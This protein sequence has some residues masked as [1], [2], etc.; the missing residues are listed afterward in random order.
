M[1]RATR[2]PNFSLRTGCPILKLRADENRIF[3]ATQLGELGFDAIILGTGFVVDWDQR[4]EL[5]RL[6]QHAA[7]W[8]DRYVPAGGEGHEFAVHPW[9]DPWFAF[10]ERTPG[11]APWIGRVHCFNYAATMSQ[12]KLTGDIPAISDGAVRLAEGIARTLF[13]EDYQDH[14]QR[15]LDYDQPELRGDEWKDE[16]GVP[17]D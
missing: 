6:A 16:D 11:N 7:L 10:T 14:Y 17:P 12:Y 3:L 5:A 4:P 1:L 15:L 9:L 2:H 8:R 13:N